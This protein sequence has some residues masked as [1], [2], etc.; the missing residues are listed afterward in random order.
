MCFTENWDARSNNLAKQSHLLTA[1]ELKKRKITRYDAEIMIEQGMMPDDISAPRTHRSATARMADHAKENKQTKSP[2]S[3]TAAPAKRRIRRKVRSSPYSRKV[4][5]RPPQQNVFKDIPQADGACA[6]ETDSSKSLTGSASS[7]SS[8]S[9]G[10][11][12][13]KVTSSSPVLRRNTRQR[14]PRQASVNRAR[15]QVFASPT[16][17]KS[18]LN[19]LV[20]RIKET[21]CYSRKQETSPVSSTDQITKTDSIIPLTVDTRNT[22][23]IGSSVSPRT[24]RRSAS[25]GGGGEPGP[26]SP[27]HAARTPSRSPRRGGTPCK[28][29]EGAHFLNIS[30]KAADKPSD[31]MPRLKKEFS[32]THE[33]SN[34]KIEGSDDM[35]VL[36][37]ETASE[38]SSSSEV[39]ILSTD[40]LHPA[41][42]DNLFEKF[43]TLHSSG[44]VIESSPV[45]KTKKR[46]RSSSSSS[47][48]NALP[49]RQ[50]LTDAPTNK[51]IDYNKNSVYT[52]DEDS[53]DNK[54]D[55]AVCQSNTVTSTQE[56]PPI[57]H[58]SSQGQG[59]LKM[60]L[61]R[62]P[63]DTES[64]CDRKRK[65]DNQWQ[66]EFCSSSSDDN[67][68]Q[69][70]TPASSQIN[71]PLSCMS[72]SSNPVSSASQDRLSSSAY[73]SKAKSKKRKFQDSSC[74]NSASNSQ[75]VPPI[76]ISLQEL[77]SP[78]N[79]PSRS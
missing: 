43:Q 33:N 50:L 45:R 74:S 48:H 39:D 18:R 26:C 15:R 25:H 6:W 20:E 73:P 62:T 77:S 58:G 54:P 42:R 64:S 67:S 46:T 32:K 76:K 28:A 34:L 14:T 52:F 30:P 63:V 13:L 29:Q 44:T 57:L 21:K 16:S 3:S 60:K 35:P 69:K 68:P 9:D 51:P 22:G 53:N 19:S 38:A 61:K 65:K 78:A 7:G 12:P 4:R 5:K 79:E 8:S 11:T 23:V 59:Q 41:Q 37:K 75:K 49:F 1:S 55:I 66:V 70:K 31:K 2:T 36:H 72:E 10:A 24:P 71:N 40:I 56:S 27:S 17:K 47:V